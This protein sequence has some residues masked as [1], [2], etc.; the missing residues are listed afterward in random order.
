MSKLKTKFESAS[1]KDKFASLLESIDRNNSSKMI[2][3]SRA[4]N[5]EQPREANPEKV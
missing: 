2:L 1:L 3:E 4:L 5:V